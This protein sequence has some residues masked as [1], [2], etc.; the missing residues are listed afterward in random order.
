MRSE[1]CRECDKRGV[2]LGD[3]LELVVLDADDNDTG[4]RAVVERYVCEEGHVWH[5][6]EG[7]ARGRA[8]EAPILLSDHYAHRRSHEVYMADGVVGEW[9][10]TEYNRKSDRLK[11]SFER[12][13]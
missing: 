1:L 12:E 6:G 3:A 9:I 11:S 5:S 7:R 2:K 10:D 8:G 13:A 4:A